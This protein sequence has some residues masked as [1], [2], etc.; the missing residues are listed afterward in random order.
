MEEDPYHQ[1]AGADPWPDAGFC[2][3]AAVAPGGFANHYDCRSQ[4]FD[5]LCLYLLDGFMVLVCSFSGT[6][7]A[8]QNEY[9]FLGIPITSP[10]VRLYSSR[11]SSRRKPESR[12]DAPQLGDTL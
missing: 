12:R 4:Q 1:R 11:E 6:N 3:S 7:I 5:L 9:P 2:Q 10:V 8:D